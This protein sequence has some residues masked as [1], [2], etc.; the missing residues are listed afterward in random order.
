MHDTLEMPVLYSITNTGEKGQ[1]L[2]SAELLFFGVLRNGLCAGDVLHDEIRYA[3]I[4]GA[5]IV[6]ARFVDLGYA[7]MPETSKQLDLELETSQG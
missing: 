7:W 5:I 2:S 4:F 1:S 3:T 6:G